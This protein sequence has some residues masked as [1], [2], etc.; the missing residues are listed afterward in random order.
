[1]AIHYYDFKP[2]IDSKEKIRDVVTRHHQAQNTPARPCEEHCDT[3]RHCEERSDAAIHN[4]DLSAVIE[5]LERWWDKYRVS[6]KELDAEVAEAEQVMKGYLQE[7]GYD[8]QDAQ[9]P[10]SHGCEGAAE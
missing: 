2:D 4:Y 10:R 8:V 7:L 9:V 1:M 3:P 6:L 5:Q